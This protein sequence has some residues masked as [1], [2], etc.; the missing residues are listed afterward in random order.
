MMLRDKNWGFS[1]EYIMVISSYLGN[2]HTNKRW[3]TYLQLIWVSKYLYTRIHWDDLDLI[4][5]IST[6]NV[7]GT[8]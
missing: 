7:D 8:G 3:S 1:K 4:Y 5:C 6:V 2:I